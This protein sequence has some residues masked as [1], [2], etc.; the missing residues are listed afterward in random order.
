LRTII[1]RFLPKKGKIGGKNRKITA[2]IDKKRLLFLHM[3]SRILQ[4]VERG[5]VG[6]EASGG[7]EKR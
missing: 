3:L 2:K 6:G 7:K 4:P 5:G 1:A